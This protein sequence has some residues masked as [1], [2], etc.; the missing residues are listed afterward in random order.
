MDVDWRPP[1]G[2]DPEVLA[3]LDGIRPSAPRIPMYSTLTGALFLNFKREDAAR[4]SFLLG[5][6]AIA[7]AGLKE[8][9]VLWHAH[10]PLEAWQHLAVGLLVGSVSAFVAIWALMKFLEKFSTW[11][12]VAYR[13]LL[14]CFLLL[15]LNQ[16]WLA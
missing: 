5:L 9:W 3:A 1:A 15:A 12:F 6:P 10:I 14:G 4:F 11:L 2:G 13:A 16:G 8:I 7:L